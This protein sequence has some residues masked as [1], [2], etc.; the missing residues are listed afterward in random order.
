MNRRL[1]FK[2]LNSRATAALTNE[3]LNEMGNELVKLDSLE[4]L[5]GYEP[6]GL[7]LGFEYWSP[8]AEGE[9]RDL[10]FAGVAV[11]N[12]PSADDPSVNVELEHALFIEVKSDGT[13]CPVGN[14]SA[15][16]LGQLKD[17]NAQIGEPF[18]VTY[19]GKSKNKNNSFS[20]DTWHIQ[21]LRKA[22]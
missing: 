2:T 15:E 3:R 19:T 17:A 7:A 20:R 14:A 12:V 21:R 16:M 6:V 8:V 11:R 4:P 13:K 18:R 5:D 1:I 9:F 10:Y 22:A